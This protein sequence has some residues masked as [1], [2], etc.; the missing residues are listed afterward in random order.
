[1]AE[2]A[3]AMPCP[4][5][6]SKKCIMTFSKSFQKP[7]Q[8]RFV[9]EAKGETPRQRGGR[10]DKCGHVVKQRGKCGECRGDK[11]EDGQ[12]EAAERQH[13]TSRAQ[14]AQ[15]SVQGLQRHLHLPGITDRK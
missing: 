8:L 6:S 2:A 11:G 13:V 14:E 4:L 1:M 7:L 12:D 5:G 10:K 15:G 9:D 3:A